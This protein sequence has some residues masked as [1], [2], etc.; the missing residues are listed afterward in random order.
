MDVHEE[1]SFAARLIRKT[2]ARMIGRTGLTGADL[3]DLQQDLWLELLTRLPKYQANRGHPRAFITLVVKN[4][5]ASIIK[6]RSAAKRARGIPIRSLDEEIFDD[7]GDSQ[8][9]HE[10]ISVDDYLRLTRGSIRTEEE[11]R[12]LAFDVRAL[13]AKLPPHDRV[14]C[15]LLIDRDVTDIAGV[16][17]IPRSTLR[18]LISRVRGATDGHGLDD[19]RQCARRERQGSD[20]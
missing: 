16:V 10:T 1:L 2:A 15:M 9:M 14:V 7:T 3:T 11:R 18:D 6:A 20:R 17:G 5:A 13:F 19:Y 8:D 4:H 12:D